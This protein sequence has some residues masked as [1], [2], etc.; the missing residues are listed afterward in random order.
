MNR[1]ISPFIPLRAMEDSLDERKGALTSSALKC[2]LFL[3]LLA[4]VECLINSVNIINV[5]RAYADPASPSLETLMERV[6]QVGESPT[7]QPQYELRRWSWK[8]KASQK[9]RSKG[10]RGPEASD[11]EG[12]AQAQQDIGDERTDSGEAGVSEWIDDMLKRYAQGN[13]DPLYE[14]PMERGRRRTEMDL[15]TRGSQPVPSYT[16]EFIPSVAPFKRET[17]WNALSPSG[18]LYIQ[19]GSLT[20]IEP[21]SF[22]EIDTCITG[23]R[24]TRPSDATPLMLNAS[25]WGEPQGVDLR[26]LRRLCAQKGG[27]CF[28][29]AFS[30]EGWRDRSEP[31][32]I[33]SVSPEQSWLTLKGRLPAVLSQDDAGNFYLSPQSSRALGSIKSLYT[34][35]FA[36]SAYFRGSWYFK[37]PIAQLIGH[38]DTLI[39]RK[40]RAEAQRVHRTIKLSKGGIFQS[41]I[42]KLTEW[43]R[44][45][46]GGR[47]PHQKASTYLSLALSQRG[48]CRH[49][50]YAFMIT[51]RA[52][53][54]PTRYIT[55]Q[56]HAFVEIL[57]PLGRWRR[58]D[59]GGE[60]PFEFG[61]AVPPLETFD[62]ET[63]RQPH[64]SG[65]D[66]LPKPPNYMRALE[67]ARLN[68][69]GRRGSALHPPEEPSKPASE[70]T[71]STIDP[72]NSPS[73]ST[74]PPTQ[75]STR[76]TDAAEPQLKNTT[77]DT[78]PL[79]RLP[80]SLSPERS[81]SAL[82][83]NSGRVPRD[84]SHRAPTS[85]GAQEL[86]A[87]GSI[88]DDGAPIEAQDF[89]RN[90]QVG[91]EGGHPLVDAKGFLKA[92]ACEGKPKAAPLSPPEVGSNTTW[93]ATLTLRR[94]KGADALT[95]CQ[96]VTV[97]GHALAS[98]HQRAL[99]GAIVQVALANQGQL[100]TLSGWG[101][102]DRRGRFKIKA[103][104]PVHLSLGHFE[105]LLHLPAQ[106]NLQ[107]AWSEL[108]SL[109]TQEN[110]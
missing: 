27:D 70:L 97:Y 69:R 109:I 80:D 78:G 26:C 91:R 15:N 83:E 96:W 22:P 19:V 14:S 3:I 53:G 102:I 50:S 60:A 100:E 104:I 98:G 13:T 38:P 6:Q 56:T 28:L 75:D 57:D 9:R 92:K 30:L 8:Q 18:E 67:D 106:R 107:E 81:P 33:S 10:K 110:Q 68:H 17:V 85:R 5:N 59:L 65:A 34:L 77:R 103:Q 31:R 94:I 76:S 42:Y 84:H 45:F 48:V 55:N 37:V 88:K 20:E 63:Q 47:I 72:E 39:P 43:F 105:L 21:F 54:L 29:G 90:A 2:S 101:K 16:S 44:D 74:H 87:I 62:Q 41:Q 4:S 61:N 93:R 51:A 23:V 73:P 35:I 66:G 82:G 12:G 36:P 86:N 52:L 58:V 64:D 40:L 99:R 95:R 25:L 49:R 1:L 89:I 79:E 46:K 11:S 32:G 7:P 71:R 108:P 24:S